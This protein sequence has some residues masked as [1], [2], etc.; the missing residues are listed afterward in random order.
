MLH[1]VKIN[2]EYFE[3]VR[4]N[5]KRFEIRKDDRNYKI[6]DMMLLK[7]IIPTGKDNKMMYTGDE[8]LVKITYKLDGGSY[9]LEKGYCILSIER[10]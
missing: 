10:I 8:E 4:N 5:K 2:K 3:A 9:G 1:E 6:G 7:E